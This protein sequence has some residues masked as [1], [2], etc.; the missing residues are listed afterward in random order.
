[1]MKPDDAAAVL[2]TTARAFQRSRALLTAVELDLFGAV[3]AGAATPQQAAARLR[4]DER[5][6]RALMRALAGMGLLRKS[7]RRYGLSPVSRLLAGAGGETRRK[8]LLHSAS[9]WERWSRL[10]EAVKRGG[11][12]RERKRPRGDGRWREFFI[13]AMEN[14]S[15]ARGTEVAEAVA[16]ILRRSLTLLDLGGGSGG[17]ARAFLARNPA[18]R[19]TV[20]DGPEVIPL[21]RRYLGPLARSGR[22]RLAAGDFLRDDIGRGYDVV[23][24][25]SII[26]IY[27][28]ATNARL[29]GS[30]ARALNPGGWAV[31]QD[32]ILDDGEATPV[33]AALFGLH[34]LVSTE[35][36]GTYTL[37]D[38]R[39]WLGAAGL[40]R[41]HDIPMAGP[42]SVV[43]ARKPRQAG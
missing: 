22:V 11:L 27:S 29:I 1:M 19:I 5:G 42:T 31:I 21:T 12:K 35:E 14:S 6:V 3:A 26:H 10:T 4:A 9:G 17:Y 13:A 40:R 39:G 15:A 33:E 30:V 43:A 18:L 32:F 24:M 8:A 41:V 23:F 16:P 36:G 28:P 25:S 38:I 20:F 2:H 37:G 34:M 7:G